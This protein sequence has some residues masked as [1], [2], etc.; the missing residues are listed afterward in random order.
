[1]VS[2]SLSEAT[3]LV[4]FG[5]ESGVLATYFKGELFVIYILIISN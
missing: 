4:L 2:S 1:L 5:L 3:L